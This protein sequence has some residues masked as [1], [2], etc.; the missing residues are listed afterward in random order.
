MLY[1]Y[2]VTGDNLHTLHESMLAKAGECNIYDSA[3]VYHHGCSDL[4]M[5]GAGGVRNTLIEAI[6]EMDGTVVVEIWPDEMSLEEAEY[7]NNLEI[8]YFVKGDWI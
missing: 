2:E 3:L 7:V 8:L 4:Y 6:V 5:M 1:N